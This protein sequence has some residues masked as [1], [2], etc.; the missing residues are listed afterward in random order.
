[1]RAFSASEGYRHAEDHVLAKVDG[2]AAAET[3]VQVREV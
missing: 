2:D 3:L 1:M